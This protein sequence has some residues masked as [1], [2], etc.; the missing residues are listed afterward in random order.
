M[1]RVVSLMN[2]IAMMNRRIDS[3]MLLSSTNLHPIYPIVIIIII[4]VS[5]V[6]IDRDA[7][8]MMMMSSSL[9][10][11]VVFIVMFL[12]R[13]KIMRAVSC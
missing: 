5:C 6:S 7:R 11:F 4:T 10:S 12:R 3:I 8:T 13:G 9:V 2:N 1:S